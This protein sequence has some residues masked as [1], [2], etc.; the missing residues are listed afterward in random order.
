MKLT[1]PL[2]CSTWLDFTPPPAEI[3]ESYSGVRPRPPNTA[4]KDK[5]AAKAA[6]SSNNAGFKGLQRIH[7]LTRSWSWS[8]R[9]LN[10]DNQWHGSWLLILRLLLLLLLLLDLN[11]TLVLNIPTLGG[12]RLWN[13]RAGEFQ[14][15]CWE[16]RREN[17]RL[18]PTILIKRPS[19]NPLIPVIRYNY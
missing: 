14:R 18:S 12:D 3:N 17:V 7:V 2:F 1:R 6:H 19:V 11:L 9:I 15:N 10:F 5:R 16:G 13:L 8:F 4:W